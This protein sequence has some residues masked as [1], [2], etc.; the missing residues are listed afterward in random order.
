M[1]LLSRA[2]LK[3]TVELLERRGV[4]F[5]HACQL[6]D[7]TTY[8]QLGGIP[9]RQLMERTGLAFTKFQTDGADRRSGTWSKV[10]GN[11]SDFGLGFAMY[12]WKREDRAP[13]PNPFGPVLLVLKPA[14]LRQAGD[15]AICLR[16][17]GAQGFNRDAE[18]L[19]TAN[20]VDRLFKN[21]Y[22]PDGGYA[23][24]YLKFS[25]DLRNAFADRV[26][27]ANVQGWM[28]LNPEVSCTI[29]KEVLSFNELDHIIVDQYAS[30]RTALLDVVKERSL[31]AG[32]RARIWARKYR[33]GTNR[34][35]ILKDVTRALA[36]G[37]GTF[38]AF[39][40]SDG[41]SKESTD[42]VKRL[43]AGNLGWQFDRY[44]GYLLDGT[45]AAMRA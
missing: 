29:E 39:S 21:G 33:V 4:F 12:E 27:G 3:R 11:L 6:T 24:A 34:T 7:F 26:K 32:V 40:A 13:I 30:D 41:L 45:L 37:A 19:G 44:A 36:A 25:E 1:A 5:F 15:V 18:S 17:A 2:E 42:W 35:A 16:S 38:A 23:S 20:E 28:T 10:F 31:K 14:A 22:T 43:A 8:L 9:S